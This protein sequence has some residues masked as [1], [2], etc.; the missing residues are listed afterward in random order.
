MTRFYNMTYKTANRVEDML[1]GWRYV[2]EFDVKS[3][4]Y[5]LSIPDNVPVKVVHWGATD[6]TV[7]LSIGD[8]IESLSLDE[9]EVIIE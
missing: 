4:L 9:V 2:L 8:D 6:R 5:R 3:E 7:T 1:E